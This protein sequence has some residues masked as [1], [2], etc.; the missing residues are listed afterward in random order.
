MSE[1][2]YLFEEAGA[3]L[4]LPGSFGLNACQRRGLGQV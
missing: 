4:R 2:L 3:V 1:E